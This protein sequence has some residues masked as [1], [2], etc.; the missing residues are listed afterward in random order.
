MELR[1]LVLTTEKHSRTTEVLYDVDEQYMN[2]VLTEEA[3]IHK[4]VIFKNFEAWPGIQQ[5]AYAR[6][7]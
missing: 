3:S 4:H 5:V 6:T 1:G 2:I 7:C